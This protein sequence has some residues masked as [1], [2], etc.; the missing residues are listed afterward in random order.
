MAVCMWGRGSGQEGRGWEKDF[1][2]LFCVYLCVW[3]LGGDGRKE[4]KTIND[5]SLGKNHSRQFVL[6][7]FCLKMGETHGLLKLNGCFCSKGNERCLIHIYT[8]RVPL[9]SC[10]P[11][12]QASRF[13]LGFAVCVHTNLLPAI[14]QSLGT[15]LAGCLRGKSRF[16]KELEKKNWTENQH[17]GLCNEQLSNLTY[18]P[19]VA[20]FLAL[21]MK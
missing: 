3:F 10:H 2:L 12:S 11:I 17:L 5:Q 4:L 14:C 15:C 13:S 18:S 21:A 8:L 19:W 1:L 6:I 9:P 16:E 7:F 20:I